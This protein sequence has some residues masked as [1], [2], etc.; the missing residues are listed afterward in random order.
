MIKWMNMIFVSWEWKWVVNWW[1]YVFL[2]EA[3]GLTSLLHRLF[4]VRAYKITYGLFLLAQYNYPKNRLVLIIISVIIVNNNLLNK[5]LYLIKSLLLLSELLILS[6]KQKKKI[7][8]FFSN[9]EI[10]SC[11][12]FEEVWL[13]SHISNQMKHKTGPFLST[14]GF[15]FKTIRHRL[16]A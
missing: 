4:T 8:S 9:K 14:N 10:K 12:N 16:L 7:N 15:L 1:C 11:S 6:N 3:Y 5:R 13:E 2:I